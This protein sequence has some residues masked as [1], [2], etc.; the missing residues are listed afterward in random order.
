MLIVG[1]L[2]A[3]VVLRPD[4]V[5]RVMGRARSEDD[6]RAEEEAR[7]LAER[8]EQIALLLAGDDPSEAALQSAR[9]LIES[10]RSEG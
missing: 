10:G 2:G 8:A 3:V 9:E 4:V 1:G 7:A 5:D 6:L